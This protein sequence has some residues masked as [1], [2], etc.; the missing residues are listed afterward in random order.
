MG[1]PV[2]VQVPPSASQ[3]PPGG[4]GPFCCGED[5]S[6]KCVPLPVDIPDVNLESPRPLPD[7]QV[8]VLVVDD[9]AEILEILTEL[10]EEIGY[11]VTCRT[12]GLSA[13]LTIGS[14][15][16]D[17]VVLDLKLDDISGFEV[18]RA[19][20]AEPAFAALPIIFVSG[21]FLDEEMIRNRTGDAGARLLLKPIPGEVLIAAIEGATAG[22]RRVA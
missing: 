2:R 10:L 11:R 5:R 8:H 19:V 7:P 6:L 12:S 18:F 22:L 14:A 13:L 16:P 1:Q 15:R 20:R 9:N 4:G 17:V 3:G 21:V